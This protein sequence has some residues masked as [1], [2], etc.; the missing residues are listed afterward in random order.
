[1]LEY[2]SQSRNSLDLFFRFRNDIDIYTEDNVADKEFYRVLFKRI[3]H[4]GVKVNDV[5]PLGSKSNVLAK[6]NEYIASDKVR[7]KLFLIDGD[8]EL[9]IGENP[10]QD[11]YLFIHNAYC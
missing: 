3:N 9:I 6:Y 5:T 11:Q 4:S 10:T 7:R 2:S 8:L 1:M